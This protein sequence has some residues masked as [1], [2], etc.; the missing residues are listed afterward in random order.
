MGRKSRLKREK[1]EARLGCGP[2][3]PA[4]GRAGE[5]TQAAHIAEL[6]DRLRDL[7]DGEF[8][9]GGDLPPEIQETHLED[10]LAFESV[11]SGTSLFQGLEAHGVQ[12]P[13]PE[14]LDDRQSAEKA[15]EVLHALAG[16]GVFLIG[17]EHMTP[18]EF[19]SRIWHQTLWEGCYVEKRLPGAVTLIDVSHSMS[20][21]DWR[22]FTE[23]LRRTGTVH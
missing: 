19:Y 18:R 21:S 17:F 4:C 20:R 11:G 2:A 15:N 5:K 6:E 23:E 1:R 9:T 8:E 22:H 16:I 13:P 14:K 10:I 12:L 3:N 7:T